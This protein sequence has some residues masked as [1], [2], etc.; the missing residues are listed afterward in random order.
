MGKGAGEMAHELRI[1][2]T[3]AEDPGSNPSTHMVPPVI[4]PVP[5]M[6]LVPSSDL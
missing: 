1:Y 2:T 5:G 3:F 6:N 4:T